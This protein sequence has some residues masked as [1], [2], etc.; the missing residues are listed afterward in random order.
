MP[1]PDTWAQLAPQWFAL[2]NTWAGIFGAPPDY[3][4]EP[5]VRVGAI[6]YTGDTIE[7]VS[8]R[9]GRDTVYAQTQAGYA[10][11]ELIDVDGLTQPGVGQT[12]EFTVRS[13]TGNAD[14]LLFTGLLS[15]WDAEAIPTG[16]RPV[17]RYR[18]QAVGPLARLNRRTVFFDG[19]DQETDGAR[20]AAAIGEGTARSYEEV[21]TS[22]RYSDVGA[23]VTY[24]TFDAGAPDLLDPGVF[25][26]AALDPSESGYSALQVAGEAGSSAEGV[27]FET[28]DGF[29]GYADS[30][31]RSTAAAADAFARLPFAEVSTAGVAVTQKF[32]DVTNRVTVEFAGGAVTETLQQSVDVFGEV[33]ASRLS[34][35]L[36]NQSAAEQRA[37]VFLERHSDRTRQLGRLEFNLRGVRADIRDVLLGLNTNSPIVLTG[38]PSN[39]GFTRFA[40]FVEGVDI[41]FS[42]FEANIGL[43]VSDEALSTGAVRYSVVPETVAWED[44]DPTLKYEDARSL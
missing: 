30:N 13:S 1:T 25:Q 21:S 23:A 32:A 43:L 7:R 22:L 38:V 14:T 9:R 34:T 28:A 44:V 37:E 18:L 29:I 5:T 19:R 42:E 8:I 3:V 27:L 4:I 16:G 33:L 20:V 6:D 31:R 26:I 2:G 35:N 12:V 39:L 40:G 17:V 24:D 10:S 41:T 36:A 11:F 15:D